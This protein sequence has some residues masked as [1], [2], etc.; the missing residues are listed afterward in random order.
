[1]ALNEYS[2][3]GVYFASLYF[4]GLSNKLV[5]E[6]LDAALEVAGFQPAYVFHFGPSE[7]QEG[8]VLGILTESELKQESFTKFLV[9]LQI[10]FPTAEFRL[11]MTGVDHRKHLSEC[12][13][14]GYADSGG[15]PMP[16]PHE[17]ST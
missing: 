2:A 15:M 13:T 3:P 7:A 4:K 12:M 6:E 11:C 9:A 10:R 16:L 5:N 14:P 8:R 1:M 17:V